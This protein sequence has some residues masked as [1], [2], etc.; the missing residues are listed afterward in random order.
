MTRDLR[1]KAITPYAKTLAEA[2]EGR[3]DAGVATE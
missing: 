2:G 3:C 1:L